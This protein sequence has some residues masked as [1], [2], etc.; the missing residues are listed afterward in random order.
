MNVALVT[1]VAPIRATMAEVA[2]KERM[3]YDTRPAPTY[4]YRRL[5]KEGAGRRLRWR[6]TSEK[7]LV[8]CR[9]IYFI[10]ATWNH[11]FVVLKGQGCLISPSSRS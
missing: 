9:F 10:L 1:V 6:Q 11:S 3:I 8:R 4:R 2:K 5:I 7:S